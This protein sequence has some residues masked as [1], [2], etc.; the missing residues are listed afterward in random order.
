MRAAELKHL[1]T[2][3]Q[4]NQ[5]GTGDR[6]QPVYTWTAFA[7]NVPARITPLTGR[8]LEIARQLV[9]TATHEVQTRWVSGVTAHMRINFGGR[10]LNVGNVNNKDELNFTLTYTCTEEQ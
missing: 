3:E 7:S 4:K 5:T 8:K 10:I 6:G 1:V 9:P 2:I